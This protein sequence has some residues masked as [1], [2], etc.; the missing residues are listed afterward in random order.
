MNC[1]KGSFLVEAIVACFIAAVSIV[2]VLAIIRLSIIIVSESRNLL[3]I[4]RARETALSFLSSGETPPS[5]CYP[6]IMIEQSGQHNEDEIV[7][8]IIGSTCRGVRESFVLWP[9]Y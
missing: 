5:I 7:Y 2:S 8:K 4:E 9:Q 1:K 3:A 6:N